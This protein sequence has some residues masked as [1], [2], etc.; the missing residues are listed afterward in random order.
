MAEGT[1]ATITCDACGRHYAWKPQ[2]AGKKVKCKCGQVLTVP[3]GPPENPDMAPSDAPPED[4]AV[5]AAAPTA[6]PACGQELSPGSVLCVHCG[7]NLQTGQY[8]GTQLEADAAAATAT[9]P[10]RAAVSAAQ[11]QT[12]APAPARSKASLNPYPTRKR[13]VAQDEDSGKGKIIVTAI[14]VVLIL[15]GVAVVSFMMR[16]PKDNFPP[17]KAGDDQKVLAQMRDEG[18][19]EAK[20]FLAGHQSR[21][22]GNMERNKAQRW[23]ESLYTMGAKDVRAYVGIISAAVVVIMPDDP[24]SREKL[25]G[26]KN[27]LEEEAHEPLTKDIGQRYLK[28]DVG[29]RM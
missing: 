11:T 14:A 25:F 7:Y 13:V 2:I 20:E 5:L 23:V 22:I 17:P 19:L 6:C 3:V 26:V 18:T 12:P 28:L 16:G 1:Q 21:S 24:P 15:A 27:R 10:A 9:A 4:N 29:L 8:I